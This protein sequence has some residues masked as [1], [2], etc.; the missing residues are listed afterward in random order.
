[1]TSSRPLGPGCTPGSEVT[2][3]VW[4]SAADASH[5]PSGLNRRHRTAWLWPCGR[6]KETKLF[7]G[8]WVPQHLPTPN[9]C[10]EAQGL[11]KDQPQKGWM[12]T[13]GRQEGS[14]YVARLPGLQEITAVQSVTC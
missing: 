8:A 13:T 10:P 9:A 11:P 6:R 7:G 3:T 5:F 2:F 12:V 4:S 1:M 14:F